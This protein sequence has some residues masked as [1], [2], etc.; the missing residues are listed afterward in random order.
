MKV[1]H[2]PAEFAI[3]KNTDSHRGAVECALCHCVFSLL[4]AFHEPPEGIAVRI[5]ETRVHF[6]F[7]C[8][9]TKRGEVEAVC[10]ASLRCAPSD[11]RGRS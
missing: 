10:K 1:S 4:A 7:V 9:E 11:G 5:G 3:P 2:E 8:L 6:C